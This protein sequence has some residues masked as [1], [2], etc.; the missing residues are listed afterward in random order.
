MDKQVDSEIT[1]S[2]YAVGDPINRDEGLSI[3]IDADGNVSASST[4]GS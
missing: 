1:G 2:M 3:T 4:S